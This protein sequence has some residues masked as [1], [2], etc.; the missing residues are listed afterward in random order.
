MDGTEIAEG[1]DPLNPSSADKIVYQDPRK[2]KPKEANIYKVEKVSMVQL[3]SGSLGLKFEGKGNPNSFVTI[4]VFSSFLTLVT[5]TN[6]NGY[7]EYVLDK[8]L[9]KGEHEAYVAITNNQGKIVAESEPFKFIK[10]SVAVA[11]V[12]PPSKKAISPRKS[13]QRDFLILII[14]LIALT[15]GIALV[16]IGIFT[17]KESKPKIEQ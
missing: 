11:A 6:E 3:T 13:L 12:I 15:I 8:P 2:T 7:W 14:G 16:V 4:Y 1:Y 5:K 17:K 10:T 9:E